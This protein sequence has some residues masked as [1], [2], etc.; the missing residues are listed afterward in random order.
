MIHE[1]PDCT[2]LCVEGVDHFGFPPEHMVRFW[3]QNDDFEGELEMLSP[4]RKAD[5]TAMVKQLRDLAATNDLG[6]NLSAED[7]DPYRKR[8]FYATLSRDNLNASLG[9]DGGSR[10]N[11]DDTYLVAWH[12]STKSDKRLSAD[13]EA[14]IG[15]VNM[16]HRGK[17]TTV[18]RGF[19]ETL[20]RIAVGFE[21]VA[22]G[23]A[24]EH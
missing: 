23:R 1:T 22:S 17:A 3:E 24:W 18:V 14:A 12:V 6:F 9:V 13:F 10:H 16:F 2:V 7:S 5:R 21:M 4:T 20:L 19:E 11:Q 15:Q 8:S